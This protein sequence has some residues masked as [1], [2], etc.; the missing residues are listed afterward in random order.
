MAT[1]P[2][3]NPSLRLLTALLGELIAVSAL[4]FFIVPQ[5]L[6]NG[7]L[8]G[9]CQLI[10]TFL[11]E[12]LGLDFGA[13]DVAGV[14]YFI[15]NIPILLWAY[16]TLGRAFVVKT[17]LC[18]LFYSA[19][20]SILPIPAAPIIEDPL[21]SCLIGGILS[22]VG[23]GI[24]LTAGASGGGLDV[25]GL[26]LARKGIN[27]TVGRFSLG[28]NCLLYGA[29]L[30]LFSPE[31]AI[32]SVIFNFFTS[33]V[34]DRMHQ[35]NISMQAFVFTHQEP[36]ELARLIMERLDRGLT[37]WNGVGAYTGDNVRVLCV[38]LSK[39]EVEELIRAVHQ[40]D[41]QA[42]VTVQERVR[43]IGNFTHKVGE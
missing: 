24:V 7:G 20:Y 43:V 10:R 35:Q 1:N 39:Y 40:V 27:I 5:G 34:L 18:T 41:P 42:F 15:A 38:C 26:C 16:R 29:C 19:C 28:F 36:D 17:M 31:V 8:L 9:L 12:G 30:F 21:T 33:M 11:T 23:N 32:Y 14:L 2:L 4:C 37:Y 3:H 13:Q 22:G 25:V 6:Y